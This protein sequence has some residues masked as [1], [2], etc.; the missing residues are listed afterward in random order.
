MK[1]F[2][3]EI[4]DIEFMTNGLGQDDLRSIL[5]DGLGFPKLLDE[6]PGLLKT[7]TL[8]D[9]EFCPI[10][11]SEAHVHY[12][13]HIPDGSSLAHEGS[14]VVVRPGDIADWT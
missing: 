8:T 9:D 5:L 3:V 1:R 10:L 13:Y 12:H 11:P 2:L 4:D 7:R 14:I 6:K